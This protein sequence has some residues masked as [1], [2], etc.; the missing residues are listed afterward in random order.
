MTHHGI[1]E[2]RK[3]YPTDLTNDQWDEIKDLVPE[4]RARAARC[5][6][7]DCRQRACARW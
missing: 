3:P 7:R 6:A 4:P 5:R 1:P 2:S